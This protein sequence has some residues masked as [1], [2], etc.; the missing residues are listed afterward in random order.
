MRVI[1]F[2]GKTKDGKWVYGFFQTLIERG[3]KCCFILS[4]LPNS[5]KLF[6]YC[7]D[8]ETV[9]EY[10]GFKDRNNKKIYENDVVKTPLGSGRVI[11]YLGEWKI[12]GIKDPLSYFVPLDEIEIIGNS[13]LRNEKGII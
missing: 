9:G 6:P 7:V 8:C 3:K 4:Q 11:M 12:E 10:T 5:S 1:E 13:E 2:R